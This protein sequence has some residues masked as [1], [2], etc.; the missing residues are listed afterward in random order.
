MSVLAATNGRRH[1]WRYELWNANG[2]TGRD[3]TG[4]T[5]GT[6]SWDKNQAIKGRGS[7]LVDQNDDGPL[8]NV[9]I[10]PVLK[11]DGWGE[12]PF[13]LWIPTFPRRAYTATGWSGTVD[14]ISYE[15]I[16]SLTS[17]ASVLNSTDEITVVVPQGVAVTEWVKNTLITAGIARYAVQSSP[18]TENAPQTYINGETLLQVINTELD[19]IGYSSVYSDMSGIMRVD[20]YVLPAERP[21]AFS[22]LRPFDVDGNP[23]LERV[24]EVTDNASSVPNRVRAVGQ[25]VGWLPGQTGVAVNDDP[26]SPY[27]VQNR[28]YIIEKVYTD[29]NVLSKA[30]ATSYAMRQLENLSKD[31]RRVDVSFFHLPGLTLNKVVYVNIPRAGEPMFATVDS[32]DVDLAP[33]GMSRATLG[34]VTAVQEDGTP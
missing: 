15:G 12:A 31:G 19:R 4:V 13:G 23:I 32:L 14:L 20:P 2:Y 16:L 18:K 24:F 30:E 3:L 8:L 26:D 11:I 7:L 34:A 29:V 22:D 6:L 9:F 27:S 33:L 21:E 10:R 1:S 25:P 17:A 5:G 28:G